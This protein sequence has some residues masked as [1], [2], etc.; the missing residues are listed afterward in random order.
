[1]F[2]IAHRGASGYAP[3]NTLASIN[4]AIE[5]GCDAIEFDV[6]LTSDEQLVVCHDFTVDRTTNGLGE[7]KNL[8]L[9]DIKKLDA[10]SWFSEKFAG[11]QI[12]T[13]EEV[14]NL[15][16]NDLFLHIE[17]K[18]T[19]TDDRNIE[20]KLND[21]LIKYNRISSSLI[22]SFCHSSVRELKRY[23]S[24]VS[25]GMAV[26]AD[27]IEPIKYIENNDLLLYSFH[28]CYDY[29]SP[30]MIKQFHEHNIKINC[31]T[32]NDKEV[33]IALKEM[34]VDSIFTNFPDILK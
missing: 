4:L 18:K 11:E 32:V 12:P 20:K 17:I 19:S 23:N 16:P 27:L 15:V 2:I 31:W 9:V 34:G 29:V 13:L 33:A 5:M 21:Y 30:N 14:L 26:E 8:T 10:G 3:E 6:Q 28:P 7:I 1:M 24:Q 25:I 22:S